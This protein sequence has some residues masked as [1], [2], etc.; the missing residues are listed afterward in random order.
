MYIDTFDKE[1]NERYFDCLFQKKEIIEQEIDTE[2]SWEKL[3]NARASRIALY[4]DG[5]IE[6]GESE[7]AEL[8]SCGVEKTIKFHSVF[9]PRIKALGE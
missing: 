7:L 2:L 6:A 3:E 4:T 8:K 1:R 5:S 9:T